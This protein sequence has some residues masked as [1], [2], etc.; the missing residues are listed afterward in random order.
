MTAPKDNDIPIPY[1][2]ERL[3]LVEDAPVWRT[4]PRS[5]FPPGLRGD[6]EWKRWN[7]R[8][9]GKRA[10]SRGIR[11]RIGSSRK[12]PPEEPQICLKIG[13]RRRFLEEHRVIFALVHGRLGRCRGSDHP[14]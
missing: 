12:H 8:H 5:L 13:D 1:I 7:A 6:R 4:R 2:A 3:V 10:G 11:V 14:R 9:A